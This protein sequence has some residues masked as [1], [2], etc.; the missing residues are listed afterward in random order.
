MDVCTIDVDI[1]RIFCPAHQKF[2]SDIT[3]LRQLSLPQKLEEIMQKLQVILF[4]QI[5][6]LPVS[7][8]DGRCYGMTT[9]P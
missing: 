8:L 3:G 7:D 2:R 6:I 9:I 4:L 5:R 1:G